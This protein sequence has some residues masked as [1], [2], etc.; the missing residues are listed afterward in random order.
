[1]IEPSIEPTNNIDNINAENLVSESTEIT[2]GDTSVETT[3]AVEL[4]ET[5]QSSEILAEEKMIDIT[6]S[7]DTA[8]SAPD[9]G[10]LE[11]VLEQSKYEI[12]TEN[13]TL[14]KSAIGASDELATEIQSES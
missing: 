2:S 5:P 11:A 10:G 14:E 12:G 1:M 8:E 3:S 13:T 4:S 9:G 7:E 6:N